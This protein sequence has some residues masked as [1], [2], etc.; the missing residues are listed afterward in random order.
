MTG[1]LACPKPVVL[2]HE[3]AG[4]VEAVGAGVTRVL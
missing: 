1:D 3:G 4:V 2:G